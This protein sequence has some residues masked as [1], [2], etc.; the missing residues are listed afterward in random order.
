MLRLLKTFFHSKGSRLLSVGEGKIRDK[1]NVGGVLYEKG[2]V[3][4]KSKDVAYVRCVDVKTKMLETLKAHAAAGH[5]KQY[6]AISGDALRVSVLGDKGGAYTKLIMTVWDVEEGQ[7]PLNSIPLGMYAEGEEY[8]LLKDV[9]GPIFDQIAT[10][11]PIEVYPS[12]PS[13]PTVPMGKLRAPRHNP[14]RRMMPHHL[15]A[16]CR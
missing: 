10:I 1:I 4:F 12:K 14:Y 8:E 6:A 3:K 15:S 2:T 9:F 7:S 5:L 13:S 11:G 16:A